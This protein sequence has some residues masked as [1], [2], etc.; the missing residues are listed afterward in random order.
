MAKAA[1]TKEYGIATIPKKYAHARIAMAWPMPP[2]S[3]VAGELIDIVYGM[4]TANE[5]SR[6][7]TM[8]RR[9]SFILPPNTNCT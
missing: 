7:A 5:T 4:I 9:L 3:L 2:S 6:Y 8:E 1:E